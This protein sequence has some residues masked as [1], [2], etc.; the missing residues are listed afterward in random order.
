MRIF[1]TVYIGSH[2][3]WRGALVSHMAR[4]GQGYCPCGRWEA[5][6]T[7]PTG[8]ERRARHMRRESTAERERVPAGPQ[9]GA[10][11]RAAAR[12]ATGAMHGRWGL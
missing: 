2:E 9:P 3:A 1:D 5:T 7:L 8:E 6:L 10:T 12:A 11:A 4:C